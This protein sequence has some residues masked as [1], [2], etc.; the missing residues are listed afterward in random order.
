MG[1]MDAF[2]I[3][4]ED[5]DR[6]IKEHF[7][8]RG[9]R[10]GRVCACGH[11][12]AAHEHDPVVG[13]T[14]GVAK[15]DCKCFNPRPVIEASNT[16]Y[17]LR[18]TLG[19]AERHALAIAMRSADKAGVEMRWLVDLVCDICKEEKPIVP[20]VVNVMRNGRPAVGDGLVCRDCLVG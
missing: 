4:P 12:I 14:C 16:R 6:A 18:K 11:T 9:A 1:V 5:I 10:D 7:P 3:D 17:F 19:H 2:D 15:I 20:A 13:W 8:D